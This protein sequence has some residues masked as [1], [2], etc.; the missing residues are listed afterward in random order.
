MADVSTRCRSLQPLKRDDSRMRSLAQNDHKAQGNAAPVPATLPASRLSEGTCRQLA[1]EMSSRD[2]HERVGAAVALFSTSC[3]AAQTTLAMQALQ[4]TLRVSRNEMERFKV[5]RELVRAPERALARE[6]LATLRT[7]AQKAAL[8]D[9]R[10]FAAAAIVGSGKAS[11]FDARIA[12][13]TILATATATQVPS[14]Y[15]REA[16]RLLVAHGSR[17]EKRSGLIILQR[18]TADSPSRVQG[19]P[20]A[21]PQK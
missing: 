19:D 12:L 17:E 9:I 4:R 13:R 7:L 10:Y 6:A 14:L 2:E 15:R 21:I 8:P 20:K 5:A 3:G 18:L 16:A 11:A 1:Q